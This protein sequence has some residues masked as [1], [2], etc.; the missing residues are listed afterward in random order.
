MVPHTNDLRI[1]LYSHDTMGL[2]HV[3]RNLL[4]A[5]ALTRPPVNAN[6]LIVSGIR[7][8]G[9]FALPEGVDLLCLPSVRKTAHERYSAKQLQISL[10]SVTQIRSRIIHASVEGFEPDLLIVDKVP[11]GLNGELEAALKA[12]RTHGRTRCILGLRDVL[13]EPAVARTEW[14][15]DDN[16]QFVRE[17]F[18]DVWI[19]GDRNV[20]DTVKA[21]RFS[22]DLASRTKYLGYLDQRERLQLWANRDCGVDAWQQVGSTPFVLGVVGGGQDGR[23]VAL[24]FAKADFP[25]DHKGV[26]VTGPFLPPEAT[27]E[28]RRI[29]ASRCD[30][31]VVEFCP[32]VDVLLS[33]AARV[34]TMGGYNSICSIL[35]HQKP[36]L[37]IPR[38]WPRQEQ[39]LRARRMRQLGLFSILHPN[40]VSPSTI[41]RWMQAPTVIP[42]PHSGIDLSGLQS[43]VSYVLKSVSTSKYNRTMAC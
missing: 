33:Q 39:M 13:D 36:S 15:A 40:R 18:D 26:L 17:H 24:S 34:V 37:V 43:M 2:G 25:R 30:L 4:I 6:A 31:Q 5:Q 10:D 27:S 28:L 38:V 29:A 32:E 16:E 35:T 23:D 20:Y 19:Y 14:H 22:S 9:M 11:R 1:V 41:S 12:L 21:C 3:R 42:N 8:A 7:E